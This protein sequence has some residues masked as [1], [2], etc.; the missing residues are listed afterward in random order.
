VRRQ[1]G[2]DVF[3]VGEY[4]V[5]DREVMVQWLE[6]LGL[7]FSLYDSP[8]LYTFSEL[9]KTENADLRT[10][11]DKSL[12]KVKPCNAVVSSAAAGF[13]LIVYPNFSLPVS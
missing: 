8:L 6:K 10:V 4:W 3:F 2:D 13:S 1:C 12:I 11:F 9:S 7:E 5:P